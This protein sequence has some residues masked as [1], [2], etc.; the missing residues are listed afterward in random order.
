MIVLCLEAKAKKHDL[1]DVWVWFQE[2]HPELFQKVSEALDRLHVLWGK[3]DAKSLVEFKAAQKVE[4]DAMRWAI[5]QYAATI[6]A[7]PQQVEVGFHAK[8]QKNHIGI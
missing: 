3:M 6:A 8:A 4:V 7:G 5:D 2:R 1:V